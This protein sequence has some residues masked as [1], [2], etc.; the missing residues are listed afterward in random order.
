MNENEKNKEEYQRNLIRKQNELNLYEL[1]RHYSE[2][3]NAEADDITEKYS[4]LPEPKAL[5]EW[6]NKYTK[7]LE[8]GTRQRKLRSV[9]KKYVTRA[10]AIFLVLL[11]TSA[12]VTFSVEAFRIKF[13]NLFIESENDHN[14]VDF[15]ESGENIQHPSDWKD[16]YYPTWLPD[17]YTLIDAQSNGASKVAILM[18][19]KNVL[20]IFTQNMNDLG[21]NIDN[22]D[23]DVEIVPINESDGYMVEKDDIISITWSESGMIFSLEGAEE[24]NVMI[25]ISEKIKKVS[26]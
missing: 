7:E 24:I 11:L 2:R 4:E 26:K 18:N 8:R 15:I 6:F 13:L 3:L 21:L 5:E 22:K 10:A 19:K 17:G 14:T 25:K 16:Y 20:L 23:L 9:G 1:G 12:V